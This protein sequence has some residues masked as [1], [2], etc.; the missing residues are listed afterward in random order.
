METITQ[1]TVMEITP[2]EA[3]MIIKQRE[4][5]EKQKLIKEKSQEVCRLVAEIKELG[6]R[7]NAHRRGK[8]RYISTS[9]GNTLFAPEASIFGVKFSI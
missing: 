9:F 6:G 8:N 1:V 4:I 3:E 2:K 7:V 5:A